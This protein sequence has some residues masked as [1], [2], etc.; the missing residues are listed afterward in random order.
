ME[1]NNWFFNQLLCCIHQTDP[2]KINKQQ[3]MN[4]HFLPNT[5]WFHRKVKPEENR[6]KINCGMA[7]LLNCDS[8]KV[9]FRTKDDFIFTLETSSFG[10]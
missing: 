6:P 9:I 8:S 3:K 10:S 2:L 5:V 7:Q 1:R 4:S